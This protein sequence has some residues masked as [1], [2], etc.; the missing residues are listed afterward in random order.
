MYRDDLRKFIPTL[1]TRGMQLDLTGT[2][3][4]HTHTKIDPA[5][6]RPPMK[7]H[8]CTSESR[9]EG[10]LTQGDINMIGRLCWEYVKCEDL[11][12][13]AIASVPRVGDAIA[14]A[15]LK[16]ARR[17]GVNLPWLRFSKYE[18][19][20]VSYI[21]P[22]VDNDGYTTNQ[23]VWLL[24]DL[25]HKSLSKQRMMVRVQ[26]AG[27]RVAGILVFMDYGQGA[28]NY[29]HK[30][31]IPLHRVVMLRNL[32]LWGNHDGDI[33]DAAYKAMLSYLD[34]TRGAAI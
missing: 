4:H 31:G 23:P 28:W 16:A 17:D 7:F 11:N 24:D 9:P 27:Y 3:I 26:E 15:F 13:P 18:E 12:I 6:S 10:R 8:L 30:L 22:L 29:F 25:V 32:L 1:V 20:G 14:K 5:V 34:S 33:N 21:G 19:G 2:R